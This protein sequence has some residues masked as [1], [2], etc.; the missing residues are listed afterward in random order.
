MEEKLK[1]LLEEAGNMG[2]LAKG[3]SACEDIKAKAARLPCINHP[4][5]PWYAVVAGVGRLCK[6]CANAQ[7]YEREPA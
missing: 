4:D 7:G 6:D 3:V 1:A 5:K 2:D